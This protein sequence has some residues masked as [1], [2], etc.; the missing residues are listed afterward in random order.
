MKK[1]DLAAFAARE[2]SGSGWLPEVLRLRD[3]R[4]DQIDEAA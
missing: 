3:C 1:A 4:I 2:L